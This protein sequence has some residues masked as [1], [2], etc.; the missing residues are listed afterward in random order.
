MPNS[1][2]TISATEM[3]GKLLGRLLAVDPLDIAEKLTERRLGS[4]QF[5]NA[6]AFGLVKAKS[7]MLKEALMEAGDSMLCNDLDR[8]LGIIKGLG[9]EEI[10]V[11]HMNDTRN[12][13][14]IPTQYYVFAHRDG[15]LL[16]FDTISWTNE[17][18]PRVNGGSFYYNWRSNDGKTSMGA[19]SSGGWFGEPIT[20]SGSHDC[21]EAIVFHIRRLREQGSFLPIWEK[22]PSLFLVHHLEGRDK[23]PDYRAITNARIARFPDWVKAMLG[24]EQP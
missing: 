19:L 23:N 13:V 16:S 24:P 15:I 3:R 2:K 12:E 4:E 5:D 7:D 14:W 22:R 21:R 6:L 8:Y 9:F 11:D 18:A 20:W 1:P 17:E 10:L